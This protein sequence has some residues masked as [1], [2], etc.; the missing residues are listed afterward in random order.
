M[1]G[2]NEGETDDKT[3]A[4]SAKRQTE[5]R[6][7]GRAPLSREVSGLAVMGVCLGLLATVMP[8]AVRHMVGVMANLM[9]ESGSLGVVPA[10]RMAGVA[11]LWVAAPFAVAAALAGSLSVLVQT[12]FLVRLAS[13]APDFS[14]IS[15]MAGL[16]RVFGTHNLMEAGKSLLKLAAVG[17]A[18]WT[19]LRTA[20][21]DV[22]GAVLMTPGML[23]A[24]ISEQVADV[25]LA[26]VGMQAAIT[27]FDVLRSRISFARSM[28]MTRQELRDESRES[29]GDPYVKG[30]LKQI[31]Q[32][33]SRRRMMQA[34]PAATVVI[35]NPTHYAVA[36]VYDRVKGG[37][38]RIVAKGADEMAGRIRAVAEAS[39]VPLVANP[40][41]AR[42][43]YVLPLE[44]E[45]P[46]EHFQAVAEIVAYVWR[47]SRRAA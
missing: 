41:L 1:A 33:R 6:E 17:W 12:G 24:R 18:G 26:M 21:P 22:A 29:E 2:G 36:L 43:L 11:L 45:I 23:G 34:V 46:A 35:T 25:L 44:S 5:A 3:E 38:P 7:Q 19:S 4:A 32:Q 9:A 37:A 8:D 27:G 28:R 42:A 13:A 16:S 40:P 14:R 20:W 39:K 15:P 30:R 10:L 47:L 31:R